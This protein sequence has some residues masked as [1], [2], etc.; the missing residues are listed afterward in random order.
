MQTVRLYIQIKVKIM[1][2][3]KD[4]FFNFG[5]DYSEGEIKVVVVEGLFCFQ[6]FYLDDNN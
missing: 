5:V 3:V 6:K 1:L 2:F 4:F